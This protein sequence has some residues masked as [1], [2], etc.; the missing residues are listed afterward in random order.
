MSF[1]SSATF[2]AAIGHRPI[3]HPSRPIRRF[4]CRALR[5]SKRRRTSRFS[6]PARWDALNREPKFGWKPRYRQLP[7]RIAPRDVRVQ[8]SVGGTSYQLEGRCRAGGST[9]LSTLAAL[10][11]PGWKSG[12]ARLLDVQDAL[13]ADNVRPFVVQVHPPIVYALIT[14]DSPEP[15]PSSSHFLE[16]A[17]APSKPRADSS[18]GRVIR[19]DPASLDRDALS[20]AD[21][22]VLDH[23]G[24]LSN[25][26]VKLLWRMMRLGRGVMYVA[27][28]AADAS[29]LAVFSRE[30]GADLRMPVEF[31]PRTG[32]TG[33]K[34]F[35]ASERTIDPL[36]RVFGDQLA[37]GLASL[38]FD[39]VLNSHNV[40]G[41]LTTM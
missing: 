24:R 13:S 6:A 4:T 29:N 30:A 38:R 14:R 21:I 7:P 20:A 40:A 11:E 31:V 2:S 5:R 12:E 3:S 25:D 36:F 33:E 37:T 34:R 15:H 8:L 17:L 19:F 23:P 10:R 35:I 16:L 27:C 28:E 32:Q 18:S 22:I 26:A 1:G 41:G 39:G 9:T